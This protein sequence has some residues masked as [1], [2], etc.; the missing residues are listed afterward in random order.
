VY[1]DEEE[2]SG[3]SP[4]KTELLVCSLDLLNTVYSCLS[5]EAVRFTTQFRLPTRLFAILVT[6]SLDQRVCTRA[7]ND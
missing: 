2:R 4:A 7:G 5:D 1:V 6:H 3:S